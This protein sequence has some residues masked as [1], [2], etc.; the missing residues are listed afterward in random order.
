MLLAV[1]IF[2]ITSYL[3]LRIYLRVRLLSVEIITA[4]GPAIKGVC[5]A[6]RIEAGK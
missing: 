6:E 1:V 2:S 5:V 4:N 3:E